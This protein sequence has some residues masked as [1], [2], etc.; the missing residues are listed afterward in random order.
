MKKNIYIVNQLYF[1]EFFNAPEIVHLRSELPWNLSSYL[2]WGEGVPSERGNH[3]YLSM[4][5]SYG[6][7]L[8]ISLKI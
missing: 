6:L 8:K 5:V 7:C 2:R 3:P 1:S 4:Q